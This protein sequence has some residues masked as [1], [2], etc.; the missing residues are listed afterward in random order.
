[1]KKINFLIA[2][3][4]VIT[5]LNL[6]DLTHLSGQ[7]IA[8]NTA[9]TAGRDCAILDVSSSSM[10]LLIPTVTLTDVTVW[11][12][13]TGTAVDGVLVYN[14]G[15]PTGGNGKG[16]YYWSTV[17]TAHWVNLV[18]NI[19]PGTPWYL[20]GNGSTN[21][22]TDFLGTTDAKDLVFKT[23]GTEWM[24]ILSTGNVGIGTTNPAR[25]L[26]VQ[27]ATNSYGI[28][29]TDGTVDLMTWVGTDVTLSGELGTNSN[30][31]LRFFTNSLTRMSIDNAGNVGIGTTSPAGN[32]EIK[33]AANAHESL[34]MNT[35][36][37]GY[38]NSLVFQEAGTIKASIQHNPTVIAGGLL[39]NTN[40][41][42]SPA[43]TKMVIDASGNVGIG[44][45]GPTE[46]LDVLGGNLLVR[47]STADPRLQLGSAN[48]TW[49]ILNADPSD[50]GQL[51]FVYT[52]T[53]LTVMTL[54]RDGKVG[55]GTTVT[56]AG[57][58]V[59]INGGNTEGLR[60]V[61]QSTA[62]APAAGTWTIGTL[63]IDSGGVL[64]ICTVTGTPGTWIKVGAQ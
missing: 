27:T 35:T 26:S 16:Y 45:T 36:T 51:K 47:N 43:N 34:Y 49:H 37:A 63:I 14:I 59:E 28:Q 5:V 12:P 8:I 9:G 42:A 13:L 52:A 11:A 29:H 55:I 44:T 54:T 2:V 24:R 39:F 30:H 50:N 18:D 41:G 62:G 19:S 20:N 32:L 53:P 57:A 15:T 21:P 58:K 60:L 40:G 64:Y 22:P 6:C 3:T 56:A 48:Y 61:P 31:A 7:N 33:S 17:A 4:G 1:M 10:G 38:A 46:K 23:N 25:K